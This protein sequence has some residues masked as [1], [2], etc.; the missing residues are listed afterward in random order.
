MKII[1]NFSVSALQHCR[2]AEIPV[3]LAALPLTPNFSWV[4]AIVKK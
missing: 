3:N 4:W 1:S 2:S